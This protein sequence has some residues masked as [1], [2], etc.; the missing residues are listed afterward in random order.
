[1]SDYFGNAD[2]K[3]WLYEEVFVRDLSVNK[4]ELTED[5]LSLF[6]EYKEAVESNI[7]AWMSSDDGA[8]NPLSWRGWGRGFHAISDKQMPRFERRV[9]FAFLCINKQRAADGVPS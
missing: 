5:I 8:G 2:L 7:E 4:E 3:D 6:E 1:M 9:K